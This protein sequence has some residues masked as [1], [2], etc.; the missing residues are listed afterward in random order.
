LL[1]RAFEGVQG[2]VL[3]MTAVATFQAR[4]VQR[5]IGRLD[6]EWVDQHLASLPAVLPLGETREMHASG[7]NELVDA[8]PRIPAEIKAA[9]DEA[10]TRCP[11]LVA[12]ESDPVRFLRREGF[13]GWAAALRLMEYWTTRKK[14]FQG[15]A[16]LPMTL[17]SGGAL[18][19]DDLVL[20]ERGA[21]GILPEVQQGRLVRLEMRY[22]LLISFPSLT[23]E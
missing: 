17:S 10:V 18:D 14:L 7:F 21:L 23:R 5:A 16:F 11:S 6:K 1:L 22:L 2:S 12:Q 15:K 13:N 20:L 8:I 19:S 4:P 9:F 3:R